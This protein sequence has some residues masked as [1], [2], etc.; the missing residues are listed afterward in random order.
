M[1]D[2][3][4]PVYASLLDQNAKQ[5]PE[6]EKVSQVGI[7]IGNEAHGVTTEIAKL[8]DE[9]LYIP[10]KGQAESLNAAVAA[11]IIIYYFS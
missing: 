6:F 10:I 2:N 1:Q 7:V 9:K 4:I 8:S 3:A 11:G 5:L